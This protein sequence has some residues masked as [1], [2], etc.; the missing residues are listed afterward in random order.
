VTARRTTLAAAWLAGLAT[1]VAL[2]VVPASSHGRTAK[3]AATGCTGSAH[4]RSAPAGRKRARCARL[5]KALWAR[6]GAVSF[7][8][9]LGLATLVPAAT[10]APPAPVATATPTPTPS[11]T[12]TPPASALG[13]SVQVIGAEWRLTPSRSTV[14]AGTVHV[15][16]N[17]M[18]A[19]DGHDLVLVRADGT[20]PLYRFDEQASQ[21]VTSR[22]FNLGTGRWILFCDLPGHEAK[23][24]K[25]SLVVQ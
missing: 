11:P 24:M 10:P 6:Q 22:D 14:R 7:G 19:E 5:R 16:F 8:S 18:G 1:V 15:E 17:L 20:G 21:T 2:L 3:R 12:P 13:S 25:A 4:V 9:A 23:G